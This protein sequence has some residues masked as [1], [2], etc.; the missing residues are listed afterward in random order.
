[1]DVATELSHLHVIGE[2][3]PFD[4]V[5]MPDRMALVRQFMPMYVD[6]GN[7][8]H[9]ATREGDEDGGVQ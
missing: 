2:S 6:I 8:L 4:P 3:I 9:T 7:L 5:Y 1:M